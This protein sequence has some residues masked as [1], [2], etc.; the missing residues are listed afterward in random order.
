MMSKVTVTLHDCT[1]YQAMLLI[2]LHD[3]LQHSGPG[4]GLDDCAPQSLEDYF[5]L[6]D[7][8]VNLITE[9]VD[10]QMQVMGTP[11]SLD[12]LKPDYVRRLYDEHRE[13]LRRM[14]NA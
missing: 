10:F 6:L 8:L 11:A 1:A 14:K 5:Q 7:E 3:L 4:E 2:S 13:G 12:D 9:V